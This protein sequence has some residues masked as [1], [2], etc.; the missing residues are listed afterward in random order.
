MSFITRALRYLASYEVF[1]SAAA[2]AVFYTALLCEYLGFGFWE[3]VGLAPAKVFFILLMLNRTVG[4]LFELKDRKRTWPVSAGVIVILTG[5]AVIF[6]LRFEGVARLGEGESLS[7]FEQVQK[8]PYGKK[9]DVSVSFIKTDG[10]LLGPE[11]GL[12]AEILID[13]RKTVLSAK[14]SKRFFSGFG[15]KL[16]SMEPAPRFS[17]SDGRGKQLLSI[18]V[19]LRLRESAFGG[20]DYFLARELPHRFYVS[21]TGEKE[22]PFRISILRGKLFLFQGNIA[23]GD[24][25]KLDGYTFSFP[26]YASSVLVR[27]TY[28]PGFPIVLAGMVIAFAGLVYIIKGKR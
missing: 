22:K 20:Q 5:L 13:G 17:V 14:G 1:I 28:Y 24:E 26:E 12:S 4:I 19:K 6:A 15:L 3:A 27:L 16:I 9:P 21:L 7:R 10:D 8:G 23:L 11:D 18:Y 2:A 25:I